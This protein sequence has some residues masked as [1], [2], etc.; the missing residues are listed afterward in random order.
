M[1]TVFAV[2]IGGAVG[3]VLRYWTIVACGRLCGSAFPWGT[4]TVN[5]LGS[6]VMGVLIELFARRWSADE[7]TRALLTV[8]LLGGY[9]TFS[10]FSLDMAVLMQRGEIV[11]PATYAVASVVLSV[12]GLF[13]GLHLFRWLLA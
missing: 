13:A 8:G 2:G 10:T 7:A 4:L 6:F 11:L 9:T 1:G 3:S 5:V 12:G